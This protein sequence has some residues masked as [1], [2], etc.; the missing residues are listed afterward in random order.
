MPERGIY[1][2]PT[3]KGIAT[4]TNCPI[5]CDSDDNT[6]KFI[7]AGSGTTELVIPSAVSASG[8]KFAAGVGTLVTGTLAVATGLTS[9][10]GFSLTPTSNTGGTG[11]ASNPILF[12]VVTTGTIAVSAYYVSTIGASGAIAAAVTATGNFTWTAVGM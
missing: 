1:R 10:L 9:V 3:V 7:P 4:V 5:Y 2:T 8:A 6:L 11:T 12:G